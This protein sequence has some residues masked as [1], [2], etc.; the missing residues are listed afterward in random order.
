MTITRLAATVAAL[1]Y[2]TVAG[3]PAAAQPEAPRCAG[4]GET[5]VADQTCRIHT[6]TATYAIDASYPLDYPDQQAVGEFVMHD[7]DRFVEFAAQAGPRNS[8]YGHELIPH[9]YRSGTPTSGTRSV[10]FE[11]Y[12]DTGAH[13]VTGFKAFNYDL[14][15]HTAITLDTLFKPGADPV[16]TLDPIVQRFMDKRWAGHEGTPPPN[17]LRAKVYQSFAITDDAIVFYI[18]QGMWLPEVDGPQRVSLPR[19]DLAALL[20]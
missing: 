4:F 7:L 5:V 12:D 18:G 3:V 1:I 16:A 14:S 11:V 20:A 13:P 6:E 17:T 15:T 8:P 10:V 19:S 9:S 2:A